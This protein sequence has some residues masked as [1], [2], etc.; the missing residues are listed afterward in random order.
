MPVDKS[1]QRVRRMFG[2]IAN[3]YD[4]M[5]HLLSM[6]VD[7]YWR[8]RAVRAV[9]IVGSYPILDVCTGTGDL[10]FAF[11]KRVKRRVPVVGADFCREMLEIGEQ[12][13]QQAG[14]NGHVSFVE[15]DALR[16]PFDDNQFQLVSVAYGLRNISDT[17]RGLCEMVRVCRPAG[18]VVVLEFSLPQRQPIKAIYGWYFRNILPRIGQW[19]TRN[20]QEAYNYLPASVGEFPSGGAMV[21]LMEGAGLSD[22]T[23]SPLTFGVSTLYLGRK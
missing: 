23:C 22:V 1:D 2:E 14:L 13:R 12:K 4:Q 21:S 6:H 20:Q 7:K 10:A 15:A 3:K 11:C 16:L 18:Q 5:N 9:S 19:L 17:N 8:W